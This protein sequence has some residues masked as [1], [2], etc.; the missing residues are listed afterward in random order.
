MATAAAAT[1]QRLPDRARG[2]HALGRLLPAQPEHSVWVLLNDG[3]P[4]AVRAHTPAAAAAARKRKREGWMVHVPPPDVADSMV[5]VR[6]LKQLTVPYFRTIR[7]II[8]QL[9]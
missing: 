5:M 8:N 4:T 3:A 6:G 1:Q 7:S 9:I 2:P